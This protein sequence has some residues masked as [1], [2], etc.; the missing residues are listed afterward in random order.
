[1]TRKRVTIVVVAALLLLPIAA[2]AAFVLVAQSEWGERW[3]EKQ[4]ATRIHRE[5]QIE[6]VRLH[7]SWPPGITFER[8]RIGNPPWAKTANLMDAAGLAARVELPPLLH[9]RI[10]VPM[11]E[12]R[13]AEAG[14]EQQGDRATWR[15]G[16]E[17]TNPSAIDVRAVGARRTGT[18]SIATRTKARP[19]T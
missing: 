18:S 6:G 13:R 8:L 12:A 3:L 19:S 14:L 4:V 7:A 1:M 10:V 11:L 16:G 17:S 2:I 15:F 5:V 9:R